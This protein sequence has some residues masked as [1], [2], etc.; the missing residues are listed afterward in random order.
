VLRVLPT[1]IAD[2][3]RALA[4]ALLLNAL[5]VV[6][7]AAVHYLAAPWRQ[8]NPFA[9][10]AVMGMAG[11]AVYVP[12]FLFLPIKALESESAR[13]RGIAAAALSRVG[14]GRR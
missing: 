3:G 10:L 6:A 2:L 14:L 7:L 8:P 13:W 4:P 9:Y 12:T 5:L 11:A 1:R